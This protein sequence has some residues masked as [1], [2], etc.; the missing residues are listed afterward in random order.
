NMMMPHQ[1]ELWYS[2][3]GKDKYELT[4]PD[5]AKELFEEAGYAGEELTIM[6]SR[7]Y[8][9][10]YNA[11]V[12][13]QAELEAI[14]VKVKLDNYDWATLLDK[15]VDENAYDIN[16]VWLGYKPEPTAHHFLN[17]QISGW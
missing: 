16:M 14:G 9:F 3:I 7:D 17:T 10:M 13:L 8:E 1:E 4:D 6:T 2:D 11:A 12:V 15:M 5:K